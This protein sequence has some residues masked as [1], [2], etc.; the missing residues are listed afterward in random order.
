MFNRRSN[1]IKPPAHTH[2]PWDLRGT[3]LIV[4]QVAKMMVWQRAAIT[5]PLLVLPSK[6]ASHALRSFKI[7]QVVM[8]DR[9]DLPSLPTLNPPLTSMDS[10][11]S[12]EGRRGSGDKTIG[13]NASYAVRWMLAVGLKE[14]LIRDEIYIQLTKQLTETPDP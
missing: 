8:G 4:L 13:E 9:L 12:K 14:S 7:I 3:R 11:P 6:L 10:S 5:T 2:L 1:S